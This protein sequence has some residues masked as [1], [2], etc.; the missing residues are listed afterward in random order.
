MLFSGS[1]DAISSLSLGRHCG[2]L[3]P[4][5]SLIVILMVFTAQHCFSC[6]ILSIMFDEAR[7]EQLG[8]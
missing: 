4:E 7:K 8:L 3:D 6:F 1:A 2:K 5:N